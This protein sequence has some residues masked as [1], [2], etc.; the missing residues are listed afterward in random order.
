MA[1]SAR[2]VYKKPTIDDVAKTAN[3]SKSA[4]SHFI[5]GRVHICSEETGRRIQQAIAD[6]NFVPARSIFHQQ[7]RSTQT[8]GVCVSL[9]PKHSDNFTYTY[10]H[11]FWSGLSSVTDDLGYRLLHFPKSIRDNDNCDA[12][13]D[14][15][16]DGL[17][18]STGTNDQR[19]ETLARA[20]MPTVATTRWTGL[21]D[22]MGSVW[23]D[24]P[25]AIDL[26]MEHLWSLGHRNIAHFA[27]GQ[28]SSL[29][30]GKPAA[31]QTDAAIVR[32]ARYRSWLAE[33]GHAASELIVSCPGWDTLTFDEAR[34]ALTMAMTSA[35]PCTA[36]VCANDAIAYSVIVTATKLGIRIPDEL[37]IIGIDNNVNSAIMDPP[38]TTVELPFWEIGRE[39]ILML[40]R[41]M[42]GVQMADRH[43]ALPVTNLVTRGSTG[44]VPTQG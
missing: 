7:A 42:T 25:G 11:D 35:Y 3:V 37:S 23:S 27:G 40:H 9:P 36:I 30:V 44:P 21:P 14:G 28:V 8:I 4:V 39:S 17:L 12:F 20:G 10:L 15:S 34:D 33:H 26:A 18:I 19:Y 31:K 16:I 29:S 5:N 13:L 24:D 6:L 2:K 32:A 41:L 22:T 43:V 38:L 1:I